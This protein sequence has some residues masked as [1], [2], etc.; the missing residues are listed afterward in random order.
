MQRHI[1]E[2]K[3]S[4]TDMHQLQQQLMNQKDETINQIRSKL[5]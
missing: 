3:H 1:Q 2:A 5:V 4:Q